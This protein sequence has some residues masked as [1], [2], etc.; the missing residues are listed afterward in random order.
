MIGV[1]TIK[2]RENSPSLLR[3]GLRGWLKK[4]ILF[5]SFK[6]TPNPSLLRRGVRGG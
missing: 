2:L 1:N 6:T 4:F 5:N 3:R